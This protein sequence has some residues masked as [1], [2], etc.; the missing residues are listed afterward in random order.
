M[1]KYTVNA[2]G[3]EHYVI[4]LDQYI[5]GE[6]GKRDY[7]I[8]LSRYMPFFRK[9]ENNLLKRQQRWREANR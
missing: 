8:E 2:G 4:G 6:I 9:F 3:I 5:I 7:N 1:E